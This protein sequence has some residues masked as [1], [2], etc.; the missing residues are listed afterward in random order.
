MDQSAKF[1]W[2]KSLDHPQRWSRIFWSEGT[3]RNFRNPCRGIMSIH[4]SMASEVMESFRITRVWFCSCKRGKWKC[5]DSMT[6]RKLTAWITRFV[7]IVIGDM[8]EWFYQENTENRTVEYKWVVSV[9]LL[10]FIS[11]R[12]VVIF[13][14]VQ[15]IMLTLQGRTNVFYP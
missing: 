9:L 15:Q 2:P 5:R 13:F 14:S 4:C 6:F 10:I 7:N 1:G 11:L 3:D 12:G 8:M